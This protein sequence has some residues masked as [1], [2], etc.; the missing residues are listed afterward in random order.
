M[1]RTDTGL[2]DAILAHLRRHHPSMC[3]HWF[4]DI[5][6]L[7]P[8]GGMLRM[9]VRE[10]VQLRYLQRCC[11]EQ[12]TEAARA[13]TG[14][15]LVVR[16][17]GE[18]DLEAELAGSAA[19]A[20]AA[21]AIERSEGEGRAVSGRD[22]GGARA[23]RSGRRSGSLAVHDDMLISPDYTFEHF[24]VGPGNQLA[25]AASVAVARKPGRAYNPFFIHGGVGLGKTHCLQAICQEA[26]RSNPGLRLYY[27]SC[28][29]FM[30]YFVEAVKE[31]HMSD[32]RH[33]FRNVDLLVID[34]IHDLSKRGQTQEEFFHTFNSLYQSGRQIVLSSDAPPS[35]I[36]DLEERLVSRF[37]SGL[38]AKIEKPCFETRVAIVRS[39]AALRN[40]EISDD[41]ASYIASRVDTSIR[42]LEGAITKVQGVSMLTDEPITLTLAQRALGEPAMNGNG[43]P[44]MQRII[45]VVSSYYDVKLS[46][47]MSKRRKK[48]ITLPRQVGMW[49]ARKYTRHS[50]EEIGG[51]FGGRDHTT[52]IYAL[53]MVESRRDAD[54]TVRH[55]VG[56]IETQLASDH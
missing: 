30:S 44:S 48:S 33:R 23:G 25:H 1:G 5:E 13:V 56:R 29:G 34:D 54:P 35:E 6:P 52:V 40:I 28:N 42:E 36:P 37:N 16:F 51:Y 55:D 26:M 21:E 11:I 43:V 50:L 53:K 41:I 47:L 49:L 9:L 10:L 38:V 15:L 19:G 22:A 45:D 18:E 39:K 32:F 14:H 7:E 3:R 8:R 46:D 4:E 24:V 27:I 17:V 2:R 31:G 12:F 20:W